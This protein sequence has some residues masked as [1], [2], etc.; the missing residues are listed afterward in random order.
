MK[1]NPTAHDPR[2]CRLC[3]PFR[4]PSGAKARKQLVAALAPTRKPMDEVGK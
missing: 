2:T 4:H 1:P 3:A